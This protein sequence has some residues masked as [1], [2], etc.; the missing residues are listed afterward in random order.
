M[1]LAKK[2]IKKIS[3][4]KST[5]MNERSFINLDSMAVM[6]VKSANGKVFELAEV[7]SSNGNSQYLL[8]SLDKSLVVSSIALNP[9]GYKITTR[10]FPFGNLTFVSWVK[11]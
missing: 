10:N 2:M 6:S 4:S 1:N 11:A 9:E 3:E 8:L 7:E 5:D